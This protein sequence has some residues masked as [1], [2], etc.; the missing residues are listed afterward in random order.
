MLSQTYTLSFPLYLCDVCVGLCVCTAQME[1]ERQLTCTS[2]L[3][4]SVLGLQA[5]RQIPLPTEPT[6][7]I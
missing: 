5:W 7:R 2:S 6:R 1:F 4:S 3:I